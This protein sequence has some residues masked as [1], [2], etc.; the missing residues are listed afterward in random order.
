MNEDIVRIAAAM[1]FRQHHSGESLWSRP[2]D[3]PHEYSSFNPLT[4]RDDCHALIEWLNKDRN[5][6]V[7]V[8]Q[9]GGV[10]T[11]RHVHVGR[12]KWTGD[13]Y[14]TGVVELTLK[15]LDEYDD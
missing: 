7:M 13:D 1:G 12:R 3:M 5:I 4:S 6:G 8:L 2:Q 11:P 9:P 15:I 10:S 14:R